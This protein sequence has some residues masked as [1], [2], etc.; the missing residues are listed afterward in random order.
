[1]RSSN[2]Q[3]SKRHSV[4]LDPAVAPRL[5]RW[6]L[7]LTAKSDALLDSL[8]VLQSAAVF[9]TAVQSLSLAIR[10]A[11]DVGAPLAAATHIQDVTVGRPLSVAAT[12]DDAFSDTVAQVCNLLPRIHV[13]TNLARNAQEERQPSIAQN[14]TQASC[15]LCVQ[16]IQLLADAGERLELEERTAHSSWAMDWLSYAFSM[17]LPLLRSS[18]TFFHSLT[19]SVG[20][21]VAVSP[22]SAA[23]AL[24][25]A[26]AH[27]R[28]VQAQGGAEPCPPRSW[29]QLARGCRALTAALL[30]EPSSSMQPTAALLLLLAR[31][32]TLAACAP[33]TQ[34]GG[35]TAGGCPGLRAGCV[36]VTFQA[37]IRRECSMRALAALSDFATHALEARKDECSA[38]SAHATVPAVPTSHVGSD[39]ALSK[40]EATMVRGGASMPVRCYVRDLRVSL[41]QQQAQHAATVRVQRALAALAATS[42]Q[43]YLMHA[44]GA[45]GRESA[46]YHRILFRHIAVCTQPDVTALLASLH[47]DTAVNSVTEVESSGTAAGR[48]LNGER[49]ATGD[50]EQL[51]RSF[52]GAPGRALL[53]ALP[54]LTSTLGTRIPAAACVPALLSSLLHAAPAAVVSQLCTLTNLSRSSAGVRCSATS[55]A[56]SVARAVAAE[57]ILVHAQL[58]DGQASDFVAAMRLLI[59]G[60]ASLAEHPVSKSAAGCQLPLSEV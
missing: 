54:Q 3:A 4:C 23:A 43:A 59:D 10:S 5:T 9:Q 15:S 32:P 21:F 51:L 18:L 30:A 2:A 7:P 24:G 33:F 34:G 17:L 29:A 6:V 53:H 50:D 28:A 22:T 42:G 36:A 31:V 8:H 48:R 52:L 20:G 1:M 60:L 27:A 47:S 46:T 12:E 55:A 38:R 58:A 57:Q 11:V 56:A 37:S 49:A 40:L 19:L 25:V 26:H 45:R 44:A 13:Q 39:A 16:G 14:Y 35:N 41:Q